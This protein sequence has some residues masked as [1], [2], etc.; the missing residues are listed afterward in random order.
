MKGISIEN[1][2]NK[3]RNT[4]KKMRIIR[5]NGMRTSERKDSR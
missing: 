5:K 3:I 4:N 2:M 1:R